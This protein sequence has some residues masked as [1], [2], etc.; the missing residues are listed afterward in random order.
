MS[1]TLVNFIFCQHE[2]TGDEWFPGSEL[3]QR[4]VKKFTS[5]SFAPTGIYVREMLTS[6]FPVQ[7]KIFRKIYCYNV[8]TSR[9]M[10]ETSELQGGKFFIDTLI[11]KNMMNVIAVIHT[12]IFS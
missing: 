9:E 6:Q 5:H 1:K 3:T 4:P 11:L 10:E 7:P 2:F 8:R 12:E